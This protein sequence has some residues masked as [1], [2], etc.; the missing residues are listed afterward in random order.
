MLLFALKM[1]LWIDRSLQLI[2]F[3][4]GIIQQMC[5]NKQSSNAKEIKEIGK[6][7]EITFLSIQDIFHPNLSY[8]FAFVNNSIIV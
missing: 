8:I 6:I 4:S 3:A 7:E 1:L 2:D 5:V